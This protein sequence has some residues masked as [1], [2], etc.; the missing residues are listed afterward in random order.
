MNNIEISMEKLASLIIRQDALEKEMSRLK[1]MI[2]EI[3]L[4]NRQSVKRV[5]SR[6]DG[7]ERDVEN[8]RV[9]IEKIISSMDLIQATVSNVSEKVGEINAK[10]DV[11]LH[12]QDKFISQLWKGFF[13]LLGTVTAVGGA[14]V[15]LLT[16]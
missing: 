12:A 2:G 1:Q 13:T 3:E 5:H 8:I 9:S 15:G 4:E 16:R 14:L 6:I 10:Q 11:A 7:L